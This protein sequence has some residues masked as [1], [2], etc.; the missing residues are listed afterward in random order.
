[1]FGLADFDASMMRS[2]DLR[3]DFA[4]ARRSAADT[5]AELRKLLPAI[6]GSAGKGPPWQAR[7]EAPDGHKYLFDV[8]YEIQELSKDLA[9]F[10]RVELP[11]VLDLSA[12][13]RD[14][15]RRLAERLRGGRIAHWITDRDGTIN[16]YCGR[17]LSSIQS[18]Y[19]SAVVDRFARAL[20]GLAL[21]LTSAP[22]GG[23][24]ASA[25]L[26]DLSTLPDDHAIVFAGSKGRE[27][28]APSGRGSTPVAPQQ[29]RSLDEL[30]ARIAN[31]LQAEAYRKF[32]LIGSGF[33][34]KVG[35]LT[36]ARQDSA[37]NVDADESEA[38][39]ELVRELVD[40]VDPGTLRI[41][42]TG[43]DIEVHLT[44]PRDASGGGEASPAREFD[45]GDGL[46]FVLDELRVKLNA[47]GRVLVCGDTGSDVPLVA[48]AVER[49]G[50]TNVTAVFVTEDEGLRAR[51]RGA[52]PDAFFVTKPDALLGA[53]WDVVQICG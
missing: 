49:A 17:Y 47:G 25:G 28:V 7:L 1:M 36:V 19:N 2:R 51:V 35:Q 34:E 10:D 37:R 24:G 26:R 48:A 30:A 31:I 38:F 9:W 33:Q 22:L 32:A 53:L 52:T 21:I 46:R 4:N 11:D 13:D 5:A 6:G 18:A 12:E 3:R 20:P 27:Y 40:A 42:D 43:L 16:N 8:S 45:K 39:L 15:T 44:L 23:T 50:S 41:E 29:Q 14:G